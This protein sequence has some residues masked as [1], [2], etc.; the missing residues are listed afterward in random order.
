MADPGRTCPDCQSEMRSI[1][2]LD[3][4]GEHLSHVQLQYAAG[5]AKPEWLRGRYPIQGKVG[6]MMCPSCGRIVLHAEPS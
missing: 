5:G 2:L 4:T 1:K 6:A 3:T